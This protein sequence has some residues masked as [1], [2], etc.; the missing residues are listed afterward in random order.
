MSDLLSLCT[1]NATWHLAP[2]AEVRVGDHVTRYVRRGTGPSVVLVG[3]DARVNPVWVALVERL[4]T[5]H[6]IVVPQPP[7]ANA[8]V[9]TWLRGFIEGLGLSSVILIAGNGS[10]AAALEV[11]TAD[12]FL[13]RKLVI[14]PDGG[15]P[16]SSADT[17][18]TLI[19]PPDAPA[20]ESLKRIEEFIA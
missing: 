11:A 13:V 14:M 20:D 6:R 16:V 4:E 18:R 9:A 5:G 17:E 3:A 12:D 7:P 19:V 2:C 15:D 8:D 10:S 1:P